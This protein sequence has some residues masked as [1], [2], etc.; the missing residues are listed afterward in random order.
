MLK[1]SRYIAVPI[2]VAA[3][4][5]FAA[6]S[7]SAPSTTTSTKPAEPTGT[8][9]VAA[10]LNDQPA[11]Q[12]IVAAFEK[13]H[14]GVTITL[15]SADTSP[16][17]TTLQTQLSANNGP[18]VFYTYAGAGNAAGESLLAK[19]G[20]LKDL[21]SESFAA[22]IPKGIQKLAQYKGK[23]YVLPMT[24]GGIGMV[25]N[26]DALKSAGLKV[27]TTYKGVLQLCS[28]AKA[29]GKVAFA[30]GAAT[31]S[32]TQFID[33]ASIPSLV[34][35]KDANFNTEMANGK[36]TF[37][38]SAGWKTAVAINKTMLEAGC[39]ENSPLGVLYPDAAKMVAGGQALAIVQTQ[40]SIAQLKLDAPSATF[41][42]WP[43]PTTNNPD[44]TYM[45]SS[46]GAEYALNA[47]AKNP[48]LAQEFFD[49]LAQPAQQNAYAMAA[50][51]VPAI[52]NDKSTTPDTIAQ[53]A[54]YLKAGKTFPYPDPFWPNAKIQAAHL[55]G[56]QQ[57]LSGQ[58][59]VATV[60]KGMDAA[61]AQ[62]GVTG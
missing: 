62:G 7:S 2:A 12:P 11:L 16:Y 31:P 28:D 38:G 25:F 20:Y 42:M 27:P 44:D 61:Y 36:A 26:M 10:V 54:K 35:A 14:P 50:N 34:Y 21:S 23:T 15:T 37:A 56:I 30:L 19:A 55:S 17:Q 13:E 24:V 51:S 57:L 48:G 41:Q 53:I 32:N 45:A 6:C 52:P 47:H 58:G 5:A 1:H 18:D 39:F 40:G 46:I 33:Y 29:K 22:K 4:I 3:T 8:L 49:Y 59:S 43:F 9:T 60:L